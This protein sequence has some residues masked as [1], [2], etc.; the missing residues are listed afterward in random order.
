VSSGLVPWLDSGFQ[1]V[2]FPAQ[3]ESNRVLDQIYRAQARFAWVYE[4]RGGGMGYAR[5]VLLS[6][7]HAA[8]TPEASNKLQTIYFVLKPMSRTGDF[9]SDHRRFLSVQSAVP[10]LSVDNAGND[11]N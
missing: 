2:S 5:L 7:Q 10:A 1:P 6:Q 11:C 8:Y 3:R 4:E 9:Y